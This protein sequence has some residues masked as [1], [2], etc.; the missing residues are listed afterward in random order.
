MKK[1]KAM[2]RIWERLLHWLRQLQLMSVHESG[3]GAFS[4]NQ[5][6]VPLTRSC[7]LQQEGRGVCLK[8]SLRVCFQ[9]E[10]TDFSWDA[11]DAP[12]SSTGAG[13]LHFAE[14]TGTPNGAWEGEVFQELSG[15][16]WSY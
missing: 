13:S 6:L 15:L 1:K 14:Q 9:A 5:V 12:V 16:C 3:F 11:R 7:F 10:A 8:G 2:E 4:P